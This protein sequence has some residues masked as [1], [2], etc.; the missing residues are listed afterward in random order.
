ML[1]PFGIVSNPRMNPAMG[2]YNGAEPQGNSVYHS[3][4]MN[5]NRRFSHSVQG[6][7]SY[8]W[9]HCIDDSSNTYGLEGGFPAMNPYDVSQDRGNCLF[10]RRHALSVSS[11]VA[12]PFRGKFTGHQVFEGW[13]LSGIGTVHSGSPFSP[14][15]G[16]D[17]AGEGAA[18]VN[19]RPNVNP[20]RTAE[21]IK[22]GTLDQ[23]FD[24]TAFTLPGVGELGNAGR[25]FLI[26]PGFWNVD[27][28]ALKNTQIKESLNLQFRAEM[29]NVLNH[30]NW[31]LPNPNVFVQAANG[32]GTYSPVAGRITTLANPMRQIQFALR[33]IF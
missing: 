32:G 18:F 13:Q 20:G 7:V 5:L 10:D 33:L 23:W 21:N 29:F 31:G 26:G 6:Q 16:F 22:I 11:L 17:Q 25:N 15:V 12:L 1:S 30:A 14:G 28:S 9:S 4:Q 27:F 8:T 19:I 3:M 24:P 2:P